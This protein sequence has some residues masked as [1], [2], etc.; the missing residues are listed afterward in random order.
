MTLLGGV[1]LTA[2]GALPRWWSVTWVRPVAGE[3]TDS[4]TGRAAAPAL[5]VCALAALAGW[6]ASAGTRSLRVR[7]AIG[8]LISLLGLAICW[9]AIATTAGGP[10]QVIRERHPEASGISE[11][12]LSVIGPVLAVSGGLLLVV[13]GLIVL[14]RRAVR[15]MSDRFERTPTGAQP[16]AREKV[17]EL[18]P[19]SA[20]EDAAARLWKDLDAGDDPTG[21][22]PA[23]H[24]A[25]RTSSVGGDV[26]GPPVAS[27]PPA[28][29][30]AGATERAAVRPVVP[31]DVDRRSGPPEQAGEES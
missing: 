2:V 31:Q 11:T 14:T 8:A 3:Q 23:D 30:Y 17:R 13:A 29:R 12:G 19:V 4:V 25:V 10:D 26:A 18:D 7:R 21:T 22:E 6:A 15:V 24:P 27:G 9:I 20:R 16:A 5:L 28:G 1:L